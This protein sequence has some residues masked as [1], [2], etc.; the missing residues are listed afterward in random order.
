M[1]SKEASS[2]IFKVFGMTRPGIEPRSP[3]PWAN[4]LTIMP[5][6]GMDVYSSI[7]EIQDFLILLTNRVIVESVYFNCQSK[8]KKIKCV[9]RTNINGDSTI[10]IKG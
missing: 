6:S 8:S 9:V 3:G 2:T 10:E 7:T 4:I 1:L 5:M